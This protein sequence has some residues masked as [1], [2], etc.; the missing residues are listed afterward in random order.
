[1]FT[2]SLFDILKK[3]AQTL[4]FEFPHT[5]QS[6]YWKI[7]LLDEYCDEEQSEGLTDVFVNACHVCS[8]HGKIKG[9]AILVASRSS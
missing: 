2:S 1:V 9:Q 7:G 4:F 3:S 8:G 6:K 5:K